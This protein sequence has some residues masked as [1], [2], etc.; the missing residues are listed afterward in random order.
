MEYSDTWFSRHAMEVHG[1]FVGR[2]KRGLGR[3][4][5]VH[6]YVGFIDGVPVLLRGESVGLQDRESMQDALY[7]HANALIA[8]GARPVKQNVNTLVASHGTET[9]VWVIN[10]ESPDT[11]YRR[12]RK[13][14]GKEACL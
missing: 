9:A 6:Q 10:T 5:W 12:L 1:R 4:Y 7:R 13:S 14:I 8:A 11:F 2:G 3:T